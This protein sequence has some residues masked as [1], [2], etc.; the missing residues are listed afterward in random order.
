MS[1]HTAEILFFRIISLTVSTIE[2]KKWLVVGQ[3]HICLLEIYVNP[4]E[5]STCV[6]ARH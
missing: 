5:A 6:P 4:K 2:Y 3:V 1:D